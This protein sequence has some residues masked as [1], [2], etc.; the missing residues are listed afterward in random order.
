[1]NSRGNENQS[2]EIYIFSS[3]SFLFIDEIFIFIS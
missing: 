3:S 1:M 2:I